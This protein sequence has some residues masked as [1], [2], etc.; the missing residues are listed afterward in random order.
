MKAMFIVLFA[1]FLSVTMN[2]M[3]NCG[4][5]KD[6]LVVAVP[7]DIHLLDPAVSLEIGDRREFYL[8]YDRLVKYKGVEGPGNA[9]LEPMVA[10][11]WSVS[12]D[13]MVYTFKIRKGISFDDGTPLDAKAVKFSLERLL[14]IRKGPS[15]TLAAVKKSID[16]VDNYTI[17]I[18][19]KNPF[20]PFL[21]TL[22]GPGASIVNPNVMKHE[23]DGDMAQA[24]LA[25]RADGSGPFR[26]VEWTR[27]ERC[28]LESKANYWGTKPKVKRV[29]IRFIRESSDR[30]MALERGD[31]DIAENLPVDQELV[32]EKNPDIVL[33]KDPAM[34]MQIVYLNCQKPALENKVVRQAL[35]YAVDYKGII[36]YVVK[37]YGR[38][39]RGPIPQSMWGH[40]P[41]V[42][43]YNRDV[44]KAKALLQK[45]GYGKG[46]KLTL[47]YAKRGVAWEQIAAILQN[48]F[49]EIGVDLKL[50]LMAWPTLRD[51]LDRGDFE[52]SLGGWNPTVVDPYAIMSY[53]FDSE[54]YGLAGNRSFYKNSQVDELI[55]KALT[56]SKKEERVKLYNAA[57]DIIM[58]DAPYIFLYEREVR[59][60]MR[61]NVKGA[62]FNPALLST[63]NYDLVSKE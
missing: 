56:I 25:Q 53:W 13:G 3:G 29:I 1:L 40:N 63:Y 44:T 22:N 15:D 41:N 31:V 32:V 30:R 10:E 36:D 4:V 27:G 46:L 7:E 17:R 52:L 35:N 34:M 14:K 26:M 11:S 33:P 37:G 47:L 45:A 57:Q 61:K 50:Q 60:P 43:Q 55:R 42:L 21:A 59:V 12:P 8:C 28:V 23:K 51:K 48:N 6:T 24:W 39:M 18:T 5:P 9:E 58:E 16:L 19:L 49:A 54:R 2:G 38:Q 62:I 20:A